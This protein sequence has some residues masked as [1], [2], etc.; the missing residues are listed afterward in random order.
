MYSLSRTVFQYSIG[1]YN[2]LNVL[3]ELLKATASILSLSLVK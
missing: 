2:D 1:G 3:Q